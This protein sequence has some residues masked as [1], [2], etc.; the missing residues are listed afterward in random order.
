MPRSR[1]IVQTFIKR[2]TGILV[3]FLLTIF[4]KP[5]FRV[6]LLPHVLLLIKCRQYVMENLVHLDDRMVKEM[7][8]VAM[9][10]LMKTSKVFW[11]GSQPKSLYRTC[12]LSSPITTIISGTSTILICLHE[13]TIGNVLVRHIR[14]R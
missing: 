3:K 9:G 7:T 8:L 10:N 11:H 14:L 4:V 1:H 6:K 2:N 13:V 5:A 12:G